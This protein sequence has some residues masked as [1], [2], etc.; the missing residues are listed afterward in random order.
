ME[1]GGRNSCFLFNLRSWLGFRRCERLPGEDRDSTTGSKASPDSHLCPGRCFGIH[2]WLGAIATPITAVLNPSGSQGVNVGLGTRIDFRNRRS[3]GGLLDARDY[4]ANLEGHRGLVA[5]SCAEQRR[6]EP[7]VFPASA[8]SK[9]TSV[10]F[11]AAAS[12]AIKENQWTRRRPPRRASTSPA[13]S[14]GSTE[15]QAFSLD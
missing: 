13:S 12:L 15:A 3:M 1:F 4:S 6:I 8:R 10:N 9:V 11:A 14:S 5:P 2:N 7:S